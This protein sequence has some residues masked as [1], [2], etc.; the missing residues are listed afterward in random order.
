MQ[1][2]I[3]DDKDGVVMQQH[4]TGEDTSIPVRNKR[5]YCANGIWF[6]KTRGGKQKGPFLDRK[7]METELSSYLLE[8]DKLDNIIGNSAKS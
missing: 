7:E 2:M 4:R 1:M 6:F 8:Q 5:Y 3:N